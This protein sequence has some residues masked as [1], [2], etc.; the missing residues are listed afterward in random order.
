M[1]LVY[2]KGITHDLKYKLLSRYKKENDFICIRVYKCMVVDGGRRPILL[3]LFVGHRLVNVVDAFHCVVVDDGGHP[4]V[5]LEMLA[6]P[7]PRPA[8]PAVQKGRFVKEERARR[9]CI[10]YM[11]GSHYVCIINVALLAGA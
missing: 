3:D 6:V 10:V 11:V 7:A 5:L 8:T 9:R 1:G 4:H 2:T